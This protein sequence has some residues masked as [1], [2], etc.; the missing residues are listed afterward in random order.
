MQAECGS[1]SAM[2]VAPVL[3]EST[4]GPHMHLSLCSSLT[5]RFVSPETQEAVAWVRSTSEEMEEEMN[6]FMAGGTDVE[7]MFNRVE[8]DIA[9][10]HLLRKWWPVSSCA[11]LK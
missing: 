4:S 3:D 8:I 7:L 5:F 6:K 11:S 10:A 1:Y 9:L 2:S